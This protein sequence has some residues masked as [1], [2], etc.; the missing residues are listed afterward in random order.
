MQTA[1][2]KFIRIEM[3]RRS[4]DRYSVISNY[5]FRFLRFCVSFRFVLLGFSFSFFVLLLFFFSI[6]FGNSVR[7]TW[8]ALIRITQFLP[9]FHSVPLVHRKMEWSTI[10]ALFFSRAR[11]WN[12]RKFRKTTAEQKQTAK[13][14]RLRYSLTPRSRAALLLLFFLH[15]FVHHAIVVSS[16]SRWEPTPPLCN[17]AQREKKYINAIFDEQTQKKPSSVRAQW[18]STQTN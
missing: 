17:R 15:V 18:D 7:D 3:M 6:R 13:N 10:R 1:Q 9:C 14:Y 4:K 16:I 5:G 11:N 8:S 12:V 2:T